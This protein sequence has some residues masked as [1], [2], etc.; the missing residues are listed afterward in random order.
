[1]TRLFH[2]LLHLLREGFQPRRDAQIRFL[3]ARVDM[4]RRNLDRNRVIL[5]PEDRAHLLRT[6]G[7]LGHD[8]KGILGIVTHQAYRRWIREQRSGRKARRISR[9]RIGTVRRELIARFARENIRRG[10]RRTV[11]ELAKLH[12]PVGRS[13][14]GRTVSSRRCTRPD[15]PERIQCDARGL[16]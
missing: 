3:H 10:Y 1:M 9:P 6:G 12:P 2:A 15:H 8:I 7:V 14:M 11:G 16:C 13:R 4:L 5:C